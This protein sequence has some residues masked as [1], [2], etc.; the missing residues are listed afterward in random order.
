M[1]TEFF[2]PKK[3]KVGF[4]SR[5]DTYTGKLAYI[6]YFDEK[7]KLRKEASWESWRDKS[8]KEVELDNIPTSGFM[9]NRHVGGYSNGWDHRNSYCRIWDPRGF[10][11]EISIENLLWILEYCDCSK[12]KTLSGNFVYSWSGTELVLLPEN[13]EEFKKSIDI[14]KKKFTKS[15][16]KSDLKP[17]TLYKI[18]GL[19]YSINKELPK[20]LW[21]C[22]VYV[23]LYKL[24]KNFG[25]GFESKL[26]FYA[27]SNKVKNLLVVVNS[28]NQ[29]E[30]DISDNY[31]TV[32]EIDELVYRF[33]N[34]AFSTNFWN[35]SF[36]N[37]KKLITEEDIS[38]KMLLKNNFGECYFPEYFFDV[39]SDL[40]KISVIKLNKTKDY[41]DFYIRRYSPNYSLGTTCHKRYK[42]LNGFNKEKI[43]SHSFKLI[44]NKIILDQIHFNIGLG[45]F[46]EA[47]N[48]GRH[49]YV[50][51]RSEEPD[52]NLY[53]DT[54]FKQLDN[55]N[56]K[57]YIS[58]S[59]VTGDF[60]KLYY[61]TKDG[62]LS[63]S[64]QQLF[65]V[66]AGLDG[67]YK[68]PDKIYLP[69]K[70]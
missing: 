61:I 24:Q 15:Y 33:N 19:N 34:T 13:T 64:L 67:L 57:N 45:N 30:Y 51:Y 69:I 9:L 10:E 43:L 54:D 8:I 40:S 65:A 3:L 60:C 32:E 41:F 48:K 58:S 28:S 16:K 46:K 49:Y 44:N 70:L 56:Y 66:N 5:T 1:K 53:P 68:F 62:Y 47:E 20:G 39:S 63:D 22:L 26:L 38:D 4:Q 29:I 23:G 7:G 35:D 6:I 55:I 18:R 31:L 12:G 17:G 11:F 27:P 59:S 14:S 52:L 25:K 21:N 50:S 36:D 37:I 42:Y 2:T